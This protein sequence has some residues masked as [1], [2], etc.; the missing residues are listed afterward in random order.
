MERKFKGLRVDGSGWIV[1]DVCNNFNG[2]MSIM[3]NP[4]FAMR[5]EDGEDD[6]GRPTFEKDTL[7]IGGW[8][9]V[10]PES[11]GMFSGF[12]DK[13]GTDIFQGDKIRVYLE[14]V[15]IEAIC[16]FGSAIRQIFENEV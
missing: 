1:G 9:D 6:N 3:P 7:S 16:C 8:L 12:K 15:D 10:V 2:G 5:I 4:Y 14:D 11:A 13:N